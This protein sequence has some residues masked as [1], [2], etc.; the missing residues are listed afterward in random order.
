VLQTR[1]NRQLAATRAAV[2]AATAPAEAASSRADAV[3]TLIELELADVML[4]GVLR[5]LHRLAATGPTSTGAA[6]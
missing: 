3:A 1:L 4:R 6:A 2:V 5:T